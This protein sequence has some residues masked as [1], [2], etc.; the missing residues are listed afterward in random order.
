MACDYINIEPQPEQFS[1]PAS[2]LR[3]RPY[4]RAL[5]SRPRSLGSVRS[6]FKDS[7]YFWIYMLSQFFGSAL[8]LIWIRISVLKNRIRNLLFF[9]IVYICIKTDN[10]VDSS[11]TSLIMYICNLT[12]NKCPLGKV[13]WFPEIS[14]DFIVILA[15]YF[16]HGPA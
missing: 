1:T 10:F 14:V 12:I 8:Y 16:L 2:Q 4:S 13:L 6:A 15:D 7:S 5:W 3:S 9:F 11:F